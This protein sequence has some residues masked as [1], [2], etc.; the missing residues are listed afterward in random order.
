MAY[1]F[2]EKKRIRKDF[3]KLVETMEVPFLLSTQIDSYRQFLQ[4]DIPPH[5]RQD[6]GLHG[7]FRSVFPMSS[8]NGAAALEYVGYRL[9]EPAF[10]E[11]ECRVRSMTY[12]ASLKVTTRLVIYDRDSTDRKVKAIRE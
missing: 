10:D 2:T 12:A 3:R 9:D 11:K 6:S 4:A 5:K 8:Y 7:A 1:S